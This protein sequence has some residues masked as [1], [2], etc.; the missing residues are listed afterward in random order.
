MVATRKKMKG[1]TYP[2]MTKEKQA[3]SMKE[4]TKSWLETGICGL[5]DSHEVNDL[6]AFKDHWVL[7]TNSQKNVR[8]PLGNLD[9]TDL[10]SIVG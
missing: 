10:H 9:T 8:H 2:F 3:L 4:D 6:Q 7:P 1:L 5:W